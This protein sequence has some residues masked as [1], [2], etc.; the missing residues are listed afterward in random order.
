MSKLANPH[1]RTRPHYGL[2]K[3]TT[4]ATNPGLQGSAMPGS[5]GGTVANGT[6]YRQVVPVAGC[7]S[8]RVRLLTVGATGTLNLKP[9]RPV[10]AAPNDESV[11]GLGGEID[12][13]KVTAYGTGTGTAAVVAATE[14]K[15]DLALNGENYVLVEFVC[16]ANGTI[17]FCDVCTLLQTS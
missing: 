12:P 14:L 5:T 6:T 15:V 8:I 2:N 1:I 4:A 13:T 3:S 11:V 7:N 10:P 9:I 16:T 17:T